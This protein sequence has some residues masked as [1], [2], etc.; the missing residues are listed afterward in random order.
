L[1]NGFFVERIYKKLNNDKVEEFKKDKE[2]RILVN[3]GDKILTE[4][5]FSTNMKR[6]HVALI[7]YLP[8]IF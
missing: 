6:Y 1:D 2:G 8:G 5:N 7:D 4:I 3:I